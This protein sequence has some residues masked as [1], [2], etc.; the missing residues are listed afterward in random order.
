M[1][2][3]GLSPEEMRRFFVVGGECN[4]LLQCDGDGRLQPVPDEAWQ[5]EELKGPK[6]RRWDP[7]M[8]D[9]VLDVAEAS[10]RTS[11]A[12]LR[13]RARVRFA[14]ITP[15]TAGSAPLHTH[16]RAAHGHPRSSGCLVEVHRP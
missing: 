14:H 10:M 16:P 3:A 12:D 5:A 9:R 13:L 7:G 6:P 11:V 2:S 4:Y 15:R 8:V 1:R